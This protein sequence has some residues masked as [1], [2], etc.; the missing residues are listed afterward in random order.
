MPQAACALAQFWRNKC[1]T[2]VLQSAKVGSSARL[3]IQAMCA[4]TIPP[5]LAAA[6]STADCAAP[7]PPG[8]LPR[9]LQIKVAAAAAADLAP[10]H[11]QQREH[12]RVRQLALV[13]AG[14]T[15]RDLPC[16]FGVQVGASRHLPSRKWQ[17]NAAL[18]PGMFRSS[19]PQW[20]TNL[21]H[22]TPVSG[23]MSLPSWALTQ[24]LSHK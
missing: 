2:V 18:L 12:E 5:M 22:M 11:A 17:I 21:R 7:A 20:L 24:R 9:S 19:A 15:H 8:L 3:V 4:A 16:V 10:Q 1:E 13:V 23:L 14:H 6:S